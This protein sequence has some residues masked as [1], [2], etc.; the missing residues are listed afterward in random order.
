MYA[1]FLSISEVHVEVHVWMFFVVISNVLFIHDWNEY[2]FYEFY[3]LYVNVLV[4]WAN[5]F[6]IELAYFHF[7][8]Y[9]VNIGG[10]LISRLCVARWYSKI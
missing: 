4:P 1:F 9:C 10:E 2:G 3:C 7:F 6:T 5:N 8:D